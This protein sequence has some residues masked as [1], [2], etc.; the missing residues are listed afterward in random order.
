MEKRRTYTAEFKPQIVLDLLTERKTLAE[1]C[2]EHHLAS[3]VVC[4]WRDQLTTM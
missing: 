3:S 2:R 1:I 4:R